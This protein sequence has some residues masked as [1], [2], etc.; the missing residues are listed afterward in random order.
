MNAAC[1][2]SHLLHLHACGDRLITLG[3]EGTSHTIGAGI[4]SDSKIISSVTKTFIPEKGGIHPREAAEHHF[5]NID[6]V[7]RSSLSEAGISFEDIDLVA[8]SKGPGLGPCLRIAATAARAISLRYRKPIVGVNHALGHLEV[9]RTAA[10]FSDPAVLYVSGG[11]TQVIM[12]HDGYYRIFG[13]TMDIGLG[14]MIDKFARHIGLAFPGG[15]K[16]EALAAAGNRLL[17]FPYS[18]KGMDTSFSGIL[19]AAIH[20]ADKGY[21]A[22][23]ISYSIQENCFAMLIEVLERGLKHLSKSEMILTGGVAVNRRFRE[24]FRILGEDLGIESYAA[25]PKFCGD[26]GAMIAVAGE[27]IYRTEGPHKIP[28]TAVS[29]R[30]RIDETPARWIKESG[31]KK[32]IAAGAEAD[33]RTGEI[34]SR[35]CIYKTRI[36]KRYRNHDLDQ[37]MRKSRM[38]NEFLMLH[39]MEDSGITV[40]AVYLYDAQSMTIVLERLNGFLLRDQIEEMTKMELSSTLEKLIE[41]VSRMHR[42]G[43]SHGD[44]TTSNIFLNQDEIVFIDPSMGSLNADSEEKATD[45]FLL[46]ESLRNSGV[47]DPE[48]V[49]AIYRRYG[50]QNLEVLQRLDALKR[51]RRYV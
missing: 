50:D 38:S 9:A 2:K 44:L 41:S 8:F 47:D 6:K 39:R 3:I 12:H 45:L 36:Q 19:T 37:R 34:Y 28:E 24:M 1:F 21:S 32:T 31:S 40:P 11:N 4:V 27:L 51:R 22:E 46:E 48:I 23:D 13:E 33:I 30:F 18:V 42:S 49:E 29:Q 35:K 7:I 14:N 26:N 5:L 20:Y 10:G 25:P 16:I 15:P 17:K 43:I